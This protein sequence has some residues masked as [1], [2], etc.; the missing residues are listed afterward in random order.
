MSDLISRSEL[1]HYMK[2]TELSQ[3]IDE[4]NMGND[5]Y[6]STPLYDYVKE[7]PTAYDVDKVVAEL[8]ELKM[9][10]FLTIANTGDEKSDFAYENVGNA[11]DNAI[12]I[13]K[14]GGVSDDVCEWE[15]GPSGYV[16]YPAY[17]SKCCKT[18]SNGLEMQTHIIAD[19]K[20]CPYCGKKIK[21]VD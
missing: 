20:Y 4:M 13:A 17:Y 10:Y 11:L 1:L 16:G 14:Q 19:W 15:K 2:N 3:Y 8:K 7:M 18:K 12:E 6:N 21:V 5:N 9:R